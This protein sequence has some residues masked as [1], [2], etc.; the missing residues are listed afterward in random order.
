LIAPAKL[1]NKR[2]TVSAA[3]MSSA[4]KTTVGSKPYYYYYYYYY[5]LNSCRESK[6]G[7]A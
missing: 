5:Y 4:N 1:A 3:G 7:I 6:S 2:S